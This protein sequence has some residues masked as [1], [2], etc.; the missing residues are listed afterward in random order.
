MARPPGFEPGLPAREADTDVVVIHW[1]EIRSDF[2]AFIEAKRCDPKHQADMLRYLDKHLTVIRE[3]MDIVR[4]FAGIK[5]GRRHLWMGLRNLFNYLEI[6][7]LDS[8]YVDR[9]R[10]AL[11][12]SAG[13]CGI[14]LKVPYEEEILDSLR[15]LKEVPTKY[16]ALCELLLDSGLRLVEAVKVIRSFDGVE[17][18]NEFYRCELAMFRGSKQAYYA[19]FTEHTQSLLCN[20]NG[21]DLTAR[22]ASH[23]FQKY[24][25]VRPKYL[26]KFAFDKMIELEIPESVAD[27]IQGRVPKRIGAK[28]YMALARQAKKFY[29]RYVEYIT[30]L[31]QK[32]GLRVLD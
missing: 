7:G 6:A 26:R 4:L 23:Y 30:E 16:A 28:H 29:P 15:R 11:P 14:D 1:Q 19:H 5:A 18:V 24:D 8:V 22:N 17:R 13:K 3:P 27:F 10:K 21:D 9:L 20:A 12:K 2:I 25:L 31:R 32:A